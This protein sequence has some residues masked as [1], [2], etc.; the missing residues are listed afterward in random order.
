MPRGAGG[1]GTDPGRG[2]VLGR[3]WLI[4][5][6]AGCW[7]GGWVFS[8]GALPPR[9]SGFGAGLWAGSGAAFWAG[10][11]AGSTDRSSRSACF[12]GCGSECGSSHR[13]WP[14]SQPSEELERSQL[15][16]TDRRHPSP[17]PCQQDPP[18]QAWPSP[19]LLAPK[20]AEAG[21][22]LAAGSAP[23]PTLCSLQ[24][25]LGLAP[26]PTRTQLST[27]VMPGGSGHA[28]TKNGFD[29]KVGDPRASTEHPGLPAGEAGEC[30]LHDCSDPP[31]AEWQVPHYSA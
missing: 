28:S 5:Y 15:L 16:H 8:V 3:V 26:S 1:H 30:Q 25:C 18:D 19:S 9:L 14:V 29:S 20:A 10:C 22:A 6:G 11:P 24:S 12:A 21:A 23:S 13:A 4:S 31:F 7:V 27:G 2:W 17:R